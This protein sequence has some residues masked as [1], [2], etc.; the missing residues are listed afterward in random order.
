M[1]V[2]ELFV[3]PSHGEAGFQHMIPRTHVTRFGGVCSSLVGVLPVVRGP[4]IR[5][6]I[7]ALTCSILSS[8]SRMGC[9]RRYDGKPPEPF[10]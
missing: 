9:V 3:R 4:P 8:T 5:V 7:G 10:Q 1:Q 2:C 6:S